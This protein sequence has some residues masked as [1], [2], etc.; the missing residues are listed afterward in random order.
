MGARLFNRL[1]SVSGSTDTI[2]RFKFV[3][4]ISPND[5]DPRLNLGN[6]FS[7]SFSFLSPPSLQPW[8]VDR[9][10]PSHHDGIVRSLLVDDVL[11][12]L[13]TGGEDGAL[14]LWDL[15][16]SNTPSKPGRK[17]ELDGERETD[18]MEVDHV[19]ASAKI[20]CFSPHADALASRSKKPKRR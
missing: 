4:T 12:C 7:G 10:Y 8:I 6:T 2:R 3:S 13:V 17:R 20:H 19:Q 16:P 5:T 11:G 14:H 15:T 18:E 1:L 9:T